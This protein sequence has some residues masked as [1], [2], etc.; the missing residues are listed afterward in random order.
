MGSIKGITP[1]IPEV[2]SR[3]RDAVNSTPDSGH[4]HTAQNH[5]PHMSAV[6]KV[7]NPGFK[8][9]YWREEA[10]KLGD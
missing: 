5:P 9:T 2:G 4:P 8:D 6:Q 10:D 3:A 7:G 1:G